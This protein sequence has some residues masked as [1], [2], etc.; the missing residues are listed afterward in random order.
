VKQ[1]PGYRVKGIG[2]KRKRRES[3][4]PFFILFSLLFLAAQTTN[5]VARIIKSIVDYSLRL[6]FMKKDFRTI[7]RLPTKSSF[8]LVSIVHRAAA[9]RSCYLPVPGAACSRAFRAASCVSAISLYAM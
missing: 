7:H 9:A 4:P 8:W 2:Q 5:A 3:I 6:L 1:G